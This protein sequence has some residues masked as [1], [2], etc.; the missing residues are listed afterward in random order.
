VR[1]PV[2]VKLFGGVAALDEVMRGLAAL[3]HR[4]WRRDPEAATPPELPRERLG[5]EA[6]P[7]RFDRRLW[8]HVWRWR[9]QGELEVQGVEVSGLDPTSE[10]HRALHDVAVSAFLEEV[11]APLAEECGAAVCATPPEVR[12]ADLVPRRLA[13]ALESFALSTVHAGGLSPEDEARFHSI[14]VIAHAVDQEEVLDGDT[15]YQWLTEDVGWPCALS[16]RLAWD[17]ESG[18]EV[19]AAYDS[20]LAFHDRENAEGA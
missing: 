2:T 6:A 7:G 20:L 17:L 12:F 18:R 19:L 1:R 15:L 10:E 3:E 11:L 16:D 4:G 14:V 5:F 8:V 13:D 9:G